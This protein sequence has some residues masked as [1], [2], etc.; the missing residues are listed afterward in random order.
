MRYTKLTRRALIEGTVL[1]TAG[2]AAAGAA[3]SIIPTKLEDGEKL[4][5]AI[6]GCG[7]RSRWHIRAVNHYDGIEIAA[8]CD[9]LPEMMA[10]KKA[11]IQAGKPEPRLYTDYQEMLK[12]DDLHAVA[13]VLPNTLHREASVACLD[14]GKHVLCEKPLTLDVS[15]CKDIIAAADRNRR[16]LQVGTQSRHSPAY[17]ALARQV[18]DGLIGEVLYAWIQTFRADWRKI[19]PDPEKDSRLNWRM[20]QSEGGAVIYEQGIHSIDVFNWLI[21]SE[22]QEITCIGGVHNDRLQDRTSWDHCGTVVRYAN[23][24][25]ATY[26]G[27]LYS[28]GGPGPDI[29]FGDKSTLQVGSR[30][31]SSAKLFNRTYWRPHGMGED[32]RAETREIELPEVTVNPS[33]EQW[34][35]FLESVQGKKKPFPSARDHMPAVQI[36]RG[37]LLSAA[38]RRHIKASEIP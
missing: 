32:P 14:A 12:Q 1:G 37:S 15:G 16:V 18:H 5:V 28:C 33:F 20:K 21:D 22:P 27:N 3:P 26:G 13:I 7:N 10:E 11:L 29:L 38:E 23:G 25:L 9:I 2:V 24:A 8:M 19:Y 31:S 36:A 34:G 35:Y 17:T 4:R 6:L 30:T